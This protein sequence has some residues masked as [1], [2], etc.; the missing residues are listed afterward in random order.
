MRL[1]Q[2]QCL[3]LWITVNYTSSIIILRMIQFNVTGIYHESNFGV[4]HL[5]L[6]RNPMQGVS[7]SK[8]LTKTWDPGRILPWWHLF[9]SS[10]NMHHILSLDVFPESLYGCPAAHSI[11]CHNHIVCIVKVYMNYANIFQIARLST[12]QMRIHFLQSSN[13]HLIG[14]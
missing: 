3:H 7:P 2:R 6:Q 1:L 8:T 13:P 10:Q 11:S 14:Q 5:S 9:E 4:N 12:N